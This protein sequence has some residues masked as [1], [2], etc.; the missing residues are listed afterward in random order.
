MLV[1]KI[2]FFFSFSYW[3]VYEYLQTDRGKAIRKAKKDGKSWE[4]IYK[5][6][7]K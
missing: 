7:Y 5:E 3:F 4:E 1:L 6:F 2:I